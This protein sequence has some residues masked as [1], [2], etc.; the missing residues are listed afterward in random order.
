[1]PEDSVRDTQ[2]E[3]ASPTVVTIRR[4]LGRRCPTEASTGAGD[5]EAEAAEDR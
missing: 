1:M 5:A 2:I 3:A 4:D